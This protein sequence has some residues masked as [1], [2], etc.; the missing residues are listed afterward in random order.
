VGDASTATPSVVYWGDNTNGTSTFSPS[1]PTIAAQTITIF[2]SVLAGQ[3][4][5]TGTY[6]DSVTATVNF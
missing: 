5:A 3:D 6:S 2:G 4:V 1:V